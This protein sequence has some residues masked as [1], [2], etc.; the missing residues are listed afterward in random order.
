MKS[1]DLAHNIVVAC[2]G[3]VLLLAIGMISWIGA[4]SPAISF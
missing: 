3:L 1:Y 2:L 4:G